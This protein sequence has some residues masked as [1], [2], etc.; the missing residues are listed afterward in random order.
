MLTTR[1]DDNMRYKSQIEKTAAQAWKKNFHNLSAESINR[2]KQSGILNRDKE[3][4]GL[5]KGTDK[6]L[7]VNNSK[8]I[9]NLDKATS[10]VANNIKSTLDEQTYKQV[11]PYVRRSIKEAIAFGGPDVAHQSGTKFTSIIHSPKNATKKFSK[12]LADENMGD[13][14]P[15]SRKNREA[16]KWADAIIARHEADEIRFGKKVS[17]NPKMMAISPLSDKPT[18]LARYYSHVTPKV[19][20]AESANVALAPQETRRFM[21]G[22]RNLSIDDVTEAKSIEGLSG[23]RYGSSPLYNPKGA[24]RAER[25][26]VKN[27]AREFYG[28]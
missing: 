25:Q 8:S 18:S 27:M 22:I 16:R 13:V 9:K 20:A 19:L 28:E 1:K 7:G 26:H 2:L 24:R 4:K 15:I 10:Y 14:A 23:T 21:N 5:W 6:I 3:L 11:S 17:Q 12:L